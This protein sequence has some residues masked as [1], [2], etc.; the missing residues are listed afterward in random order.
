[1]KSL[2]TGKEK[3]SSGVLAGMLTVGGDSLIDAVMELYNKRLSPEAMAP[4]KRKKTVEMVLHKSGDRGLPQN[5][6]PISS[7]PIL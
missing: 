2:K 7:M 4:S 3:D 1:M 6:G 5:Y